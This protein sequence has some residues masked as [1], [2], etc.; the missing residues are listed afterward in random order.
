[1][2]GC[3]GSL[4]I[5]LLFIDHFAHFYPAGHHSNDGLASIGLVLASRLAW[6]C[7]ALPCLPPSLP[8][9]SRQMTRRLDGWCDPPCS[10]GIMWSGS[11]LLGCRDWFQL[12]QVEH[13]GQVVWPAPRASFSTTALT[14][15]HSAVPVREVAIHSPPVFVTRS[16]VRFAECL[17]TLKVLTHARKVVCLG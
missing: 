13:S 8:L 4:I 17:F 2:G 15:F 3:R 14:F 9:H 12:S 6:I 5:F 1:M 11:G 16:G 10:H 7:F